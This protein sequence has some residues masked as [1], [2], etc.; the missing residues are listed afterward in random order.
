M[1][2]KDLQ[3]QDEKQGIELGNFKQ[4]IQVKFFSQLSTIICVYRVFLNTQIIWN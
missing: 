1:E 4:E 2:L 3:K